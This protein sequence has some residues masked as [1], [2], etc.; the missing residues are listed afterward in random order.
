MHILVVSMLF[1]WPWELSNEILLEC[2]RW[3][4]GGRC[5]RPV[6]QGD[7]SGHQVRAFSAVLPLLEWH[8]LAAAG[9]VAARRQL[10]RVSALV[11]E[12]ASQAIAVSTAGVGYSGVYRWCRL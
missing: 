4:E 1:A 10:A 3:G 8:T 5:S 7:A 6:L 12:K 2:D 11:N 9:G